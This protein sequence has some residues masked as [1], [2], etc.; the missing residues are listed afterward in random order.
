MLEPPHANQ[1]ACVTNGTPTAL[2]DRISP[3]KPA[4]EGAVALANLDAL[5]GFALCGGEP[6]NSDLLRWVPL[7]QHGS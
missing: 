7:P 1:M 4:Q 3:G 2:F 5:R 6:S